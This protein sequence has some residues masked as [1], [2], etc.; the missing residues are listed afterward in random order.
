[1]LFG[2]WGH[3]QQHE[4][5]EFREVPRL[6]K[7]CEIFLFPQKSELRIFVNFPSRWLGHRNF[8]LNLNIVINIINIYL[9]GELKRQ[10]NIR[11]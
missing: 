5:G 3:M 9:K 11:E 10:G 1:M 6:R 8:S 7:T 2:I 4:A